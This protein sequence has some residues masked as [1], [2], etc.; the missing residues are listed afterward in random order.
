MLRITIHDDPE[1]L[2]FQLEGK[3]AGRS[4]RALHDCWQGARGA[5]PRRG[6]RFDLRDVT[7]VDTEGKA[8]LAARYAQGAE[9]IA[10]GCLARGIVA[11][12][13]KA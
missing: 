7:F 10:G 5:S 1:F 3:V 6:V 8:F 12:I 9:L 11:E 13:A 2:T 4:V